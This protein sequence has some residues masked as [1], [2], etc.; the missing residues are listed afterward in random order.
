MDKYMLNIEKALRATQA[1]FAVL[2]DGPD[3]ADGKPPVVLCVVD[4][5][6]VLLAFARMDKAPERLVP[7][8]I[9]KAYTA[10]RMHNS[11]QAFQQRLRTEHLSLQD[12]CDPALTSLPGGAPLMR[13]GVCLGAV[14]VS[15]RALQEDAALAERYAALLQGLL[16]G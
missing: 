13:E 9:S 10:A 7:I 3:G 11:T 16:A 4:G 2:T 5:K 12:F 8:V 14:G 6:G 15:G 1:M